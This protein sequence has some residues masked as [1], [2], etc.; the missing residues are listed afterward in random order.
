MI[1]IQE[2]HYPW[3]AASFVKHLQVFGFTLIAVSMLYLVA[4]NWFMLPQTMQLAIPQLLLLLSALS[5]LLL[6]KHDF[7]VQCLHTICGLMIGLSLAVIGQIYQTGAD[8][9]LLFLIWS[10]LL[11]P[12]LYRHNI[13]IFLL[14]CVIS[15]IA[16]FLFF[17]QT[18]WGDQYPKLFLIS[19][20]I[21]ALIQ[22]YFCIRYYSKLRYLLILWFAILSIWSMVM[23]LYTD[24][25]ILYFIFSFVFLGI[26]FTYFYKNKD[27]LCS[28]LSAVGLGIT[29][30]LVIVK[31]LSDFFSSN[32]VFQL[33]FI[34]LIIFAWFALI[35]YLLIRFIPQSRFNAIPLAVGAWI[36]GA[37]FALLMLTFWGNF[38]L[39]MGVVFVVIAA[40][41]LKLKRADQIQHGLFLRQFAYCMWIAGQIAVI[42]HTFDLIDLIL[43]IVILQLGM[44]IIAYFIRAHWFFIFI[45]IL[46]LYVAGFV[47]ILDIHSFWSRTSFFEN[48][49][50]LVLWNYVFYFAILAIKFIQPK[51]YQRSL[52]L[53]VLVIILHSMGIYTL[54]G[55]YELAKIEHIAILTYGLPILWFI[56]FVFLHIQKQF[57]LFANIILAFFAAVLIFYGYFEIFICLAVI[58]WA[59]KKQ[60]KVIYAFA[61]VT[62]ALILGFLY[63]SLEMTFLIKSFSIFMSGL[64]LLLLTLSLNQFKNKEELSI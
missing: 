19:I 6:T 14:L 7:L 50:Y 48:F 51:E 60:D 28:T 13:G 55:K 52:L 24:K 5:S 11:L 22:F 62:F 58:S 61:L 59:L 56:L 1:K 32:E 44:L 46:G 25:G 12:W 21:F 34:A 41:I 2:H 30:T 31:I 37:V 63:Y 29:F 18:F 17:I 9:Y 53:A 10:V 35:T 3:N 45:Q 27:Q 16:L 42:F 64:V 23:Y 47:Y 43:P 54:L 20:H 26:L 4:A 15:Q 38:S 8:S 49:A 57:H 40:Y 33:F 39:I 36:A